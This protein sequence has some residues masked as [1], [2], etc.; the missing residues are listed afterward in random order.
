MIFKYNNMDNVWI[1]SDPHAFHTN[2][3]RA[4]TAWDLSKNVGNTRDF[5]DPDHMTQ[6]IADNINNLVDYND[7]IW[8]LGDWSFAGLDNIIR[9]RKMLICSN[10]NLVFGNHDEKIIRN[11][12]EVQKLFNWCGP[13]A[14]LHVGKKPMLHFNLFHFPIRSWNNQNKGAFHLHGHV[15]SSRINRFFN[16]GKSMD[17]GIDGNDFEP[18]RLEDCYNLL[19]DKKMEYNEKDHHTFI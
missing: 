2:I 8:C 4:T 14:E 10:I 1:F 16:G 15:H 7:T 6:I 19:K 3:C 5:K 13:Y 18:Y 11:Q 12:H 17:V 9:F